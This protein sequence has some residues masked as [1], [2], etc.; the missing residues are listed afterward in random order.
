[1]PLFLIGTFG[2]KQF[3]ATQGARDLTAIHQIRQF[4]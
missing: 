3:A 2:T 1:M 4:F